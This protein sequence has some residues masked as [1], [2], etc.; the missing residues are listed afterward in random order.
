M[1]VRV[2]LYAELQDLR[3]MSDGVRELLCP[4]REAATVLDLVRSCNIPPEAVDLILVN[5]DSAGPGRRLRGGDRV[6]LFP[7]FESFDITALQRVRAR[8]L[9]NPR[10]VLDV[11]LGKLAAHLRML[12]FDALT[13]PAMDDDGLLG[14]SL[15]ESRTL[16]SRDRKLMGDGRLQRGYRVRSSD[17]REQLAEVVERFDLRSLFNPFTRC[18]RCNTVLR[19]VAPHDVFHRLP[20]RTRAGFHAFRECPSCRRLYWN[21]SHYKRMAALV[22]SLCRPDT[23]GR[24]AQSPCN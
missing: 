3:G 6:S 22:D 17:P 10:F 20:P 9:R 12:G 15:R 5:G 4:L 14:I 11:H 24:A 18:L 19:Q 21:G 7:V 16:L 23:G 8:P 13:P 2:R 1:E